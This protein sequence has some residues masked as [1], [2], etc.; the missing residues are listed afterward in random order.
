MPS[1]QSVPGLRQWRLSC[2]GQEHYCAF[3]VSQSRPSRR[4]DRQNK[5]RD[6]AGDDQARKASDQGIGWM[7]QS[8]KDEAR[9]QRAGRGTRKRR[10]QTV[11]V[12]GAHRSGPAYKPK[13]QWVQDAQAAQRKRKR[14]TCR[15]PL[16]PND[17]EED[18]KRRVD[19]RPIKHV[20]STPL[21]Y[22]QPTN[23]AYRLNQSRDGQENKYAARRFPLRP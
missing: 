18:C 9:R 19:Q 11:E 13:H 12:A 22:Q 20:L 14:H 17:N 4:K 7:R 21:R 3:D 1:T 5:Q 16:Q 23:S 6:G 8:A 10:Y 15:S 2:S